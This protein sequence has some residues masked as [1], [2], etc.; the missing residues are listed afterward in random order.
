MSKKRTIQ[1][2]NCKTKQKKKRNEQKRIQETVLKAKRKR[3]NDK[4]EAA[5]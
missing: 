2:L 4:K 3:K 5:R 1:I